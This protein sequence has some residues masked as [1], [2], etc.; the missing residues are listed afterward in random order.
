MDR[1]QGNLS[2]EHSEEQKASAYPGELSEAPAST[3]LFSPVV[4]LSWLMYF[5]DN[6]HSFWVESLREGPSLYDRRKGFRD[7]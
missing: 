5:D 6:L 1:R 7:F 4:N 3:S 2:E